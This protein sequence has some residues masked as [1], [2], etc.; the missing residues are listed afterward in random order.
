MS[1]KY[2]ICPKHNCTH[3]CDHKE[4][5]PQT[6]NCRVKCEQ[7][8]YA[9]REISLEKAQRLIRYERK[10]E[11]RKVTINSESATEVTRYKKLVAK[12]NI[13]RKYILIGD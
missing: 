10:I 6:E 1:I 11:M 13:F 2:A 9:C 4:P 3:R 5:H 8:S 7:H 12:R